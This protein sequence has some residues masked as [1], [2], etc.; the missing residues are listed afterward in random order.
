MADTGGIAAGIITV[1]GLG[2]CFLLLL[3]CVVLLSRAW[4]Q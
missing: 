4:K 1:L 2:T 3:Y